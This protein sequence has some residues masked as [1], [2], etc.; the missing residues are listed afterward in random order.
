MDLWNNSDNKLVSVGDF[1]AAARRAVEQNFPACWISGEVANFA[2]AASGHWYFVLRDDA[3]QADCVM[4]RK[5]NALLSA[6][7]QTGDAVEVLAQA[8]IYAP[9][10]RFQLMARFVRRAGAGRFYEMFLRRK[11]EWAARGW[12][13]AESKKTPPFWPETV[14]VVGSAEGAAVRDVLRTLK[15]RMPSVNVIVYPAP[16]QGAGAAEKIAAAI[17]TANRRYEC[18]TLL[19]CRGGGGMEDLWAYNEEPVVRA[20]FESRLPIITGI[21]HEI[22]ETLADFAADMRAPTPTGAAILA[23]PDKKELRGK[24]RAAA[25]SFL[26]AASRAADDVAQKLD[27]AAAVFLRPSALWHEKNASLKQTA[28]QFSAAAAGAHSEILLRFNS[29]AMRLRRPQFFGQNE[30]LRALAEKI[31]A[32]VKQNMQNAE[33]RLRRAEAIIET[34]NPQNTLARGY[35]IIRNAAGNVITD[36]GKL[37]PGDELR[38]QFAKGGARAEVLRGEKEK[39]D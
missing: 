19:V 10:G 30:T 38:L 35:G 12:F 31:P 17:K 18:Q 1:I 15:T 3:G 27:W 22:D 9:R 29:A 28:A 11:A 5:F 33:F 34:C 36:G 32:A 14:G 21:G 37:N 24:L 16:A 20:V 13:S 6:P 7:L 8:S 25:E 39:T 4:L 2:R 26:R 23:A